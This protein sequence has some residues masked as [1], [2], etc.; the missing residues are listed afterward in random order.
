[1]RLRFRHVYGISLAFPFALASMAQ[2]A[3]PPFRA[4]VIL[5][6]GELAPSV[7]ISAPVL[8]Y[9]VDAGSSR[10]R[11]ILGIP[12]SGFAADVNAPGAGAASVRVSPGQDYALI[13]MADSGSLARLSLG[14]AS[15]SQAL[16]AGAMTGVTFVAF[17][18]TGA[19]ALA[20]SESLR[21]AQVFTGFPDS[22]ALSREFDWSVL[23]GRVTAAAINDA[24]D[25]ALAAV[26]NISA[27]LY[28]VSTSGFASI[29]SAQAVSGLAFLRNSREALITAPAEKQLIWIRDAAGVPSPTLLA[30][31]S[32]GLSAPQA[33]AA[34][35]DGGRAFVLD[36][37]SGLMAIPLTGAPPVRI[38]CACLPSQLQPM[39]G[40]DVFLLT[41]SSDSPL[42]VLDAGGDEL[43]VVMMAPDPP[44]ST[45][46]AGGTK[47]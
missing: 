10:L 33:V 35:Q 22:P 38:G 32:A 40:R 29:Y 11:S 5:G 8:G 17:S 31:A 45:L 23:P 41:T 12:G 18:P 39:R 37:V 46:S 4:A 1:M 25:F 20:Y 28:A 16:L 13:V 9:F 21:K 3:A 14:A 19:A 44:V 42:A 34:S 2:P 27:M 26:Q 6:R 36:A 15:P 30:G 47:Q 24:G 43:K 7:T